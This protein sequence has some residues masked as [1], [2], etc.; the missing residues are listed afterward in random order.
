MNFVDALRLAGTNQ[1]LVSPGSQNQPQAAAT[2]ATNLP[3]AQISVAQAGLTE[4]EE[5]HTTVF[6]ENDG[7]SVVRLELRL[8][9]EQTY[10]LVKTA[11]GYTHRYMTLREA[12][13]YLR[14]RPSVLT[15]LAQQGSVPGF[16][17]EGSWRFEKS[18]IDRWVQHRAAPANDPTNFDTS[19]NAA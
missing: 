2:A 17:I 6:Q 10:A 4:E 14:L 16:Q 1:P 8:N 5:I 15:E 19:E 7:T 18:A 13:S 11:M 3:E 12:A 9:A